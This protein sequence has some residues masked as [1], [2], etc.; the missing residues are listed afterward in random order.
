MH[1]V[2]SEKTAVKNQILAVPVFNLFVVAK[3]G[4]CLYNLRHGHTGQR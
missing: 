2:E 1:E 4:V 3:C